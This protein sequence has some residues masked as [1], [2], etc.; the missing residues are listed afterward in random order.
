MAYDVRVLADEDA[1]ASWE[2]GRI[3]FGGPRQPPENWGRPDPARTTF[4]AF[5]SASRLV[6][7]AVDR[8]QRH[9]FGGKLLPASG[10]AG[11]AVVPDLRGRGVIGQVIAPLLAFA[12]DRGAVI[13]TLFDTTPVPYRRLGWEEVGALTWW[14]LPTRALA[15]VRA[16]E[17]IT[18]RPATAA[19][20]PSI[21]ELYETV[22]RA[23]SGMMDRTGPTFD[24]SAETMIGG[25]DGVTLAVDQDAT[26]VGYASWNRG[27]GYDESGR[28]TVYDLI[29]LTP[30]ATTALLGMLAG[31]ANVAPTLELRLPEPDP[32][33][34]L[35]PSTGVALRSRQPWMLRIVDAPGAVA[36]RGWPPLLDAAVDLLLDD[37]VCPWNSGPHRLVL[38][39]GSGRLEPGGAATVRLSMRGFALLYAGGGGPALLRR[40]GLMT[41]GDER[42][43][44]VLQA[45]AAGPRPTLLDYF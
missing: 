12:R 42:T 37:E 34:L 11:V 36:A 41:G 5:D 3:A 13:S 21:F 18:L 33:F 6:A 32:A 28:L 20:V 45:A 35:A 26:P 38:S 1:D 22:A 10:I 14:T 7:K 15:R 17:H 4:G 30:D 43:D 29:G 31:W 16:P 23:S 8:Q 39:G 9:W 44:A 19:D 27:G 2:L 24:T 25:L 40:A